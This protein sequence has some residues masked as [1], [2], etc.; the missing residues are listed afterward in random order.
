MI[1][2]VGKTRA[3][4]PRDGFSLVE[5]ALV[6][7]FLL[8]AVGGLASAVVSALRLSRTTEETSKADDAV[9]E[10]AAE[11]QSAVFADIFHSY[12]GNPGD[13]P[14]GA[15]TAP[16]GTFDVL[17]LTPRRDDPDGRVGR[18][19]FPALPIGAGPAEALREDV[20]D[21]R[22]GMDAGR[23]LNGDGNVDALDHSA[24]YIALPARLIVE[25]S[26]A[27]GPRSV[28]LDL[29]LVP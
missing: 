20:V 18:I 10:L 29:F 12:N 28:E 17:G 6:T 11:M 7:V 16:G 1:Q 24:D 9:R 21:A 22:L 27:G 15:G 14:A 23:D 25:W 8:V 13:D 19:V 26:G 4:S 3:Y 2:R 5:I